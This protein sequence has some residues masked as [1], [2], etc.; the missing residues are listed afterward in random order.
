MGSERGAAPEMSGRHGIIKRMCRRMVR[1]WAGRASWVVMGLSLTILASGAVWAR[2]GSVPERSDTGL[3]SFSAGG[4]GTP[5]TPPATMRI[6]TLGG[7]AMSITLPGG[8]SMEFV[9]VPAG[10]FQM[11]SNDDSSWSWCHPC[12][13]PVRTVNI[14]E[15]FYLGRF[16]VTQAQWLAVMG[17][18]PGEA[19]SAEFGLGG[20]HPAYNISWNDVQEFIAALNSYITSTGQGPADLRLPSEAEWEYACRAGTRTQYYFGDSDCEPTDCD[21]CELDDHAW[22]CGNAGGRTHATGQLRPNALGLYDMSGNVWEWCEDAWHEN[23]ADPSRP[24]DGSP[25]LIPTA[26]ARVLRGGAWNNHA[27]FG[28]SSA[29][30]GNSQDGPDRCIGFR[31]ARPRSSQADSKAHRSWRMYE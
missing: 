25:W 28:R 23:Y 1:R 17:S 8:L 24:D 13:Q 30:I 27:Q 21:S 9:R 4:N 20:D 26:S 18:W 31:L 14:D 22:W 7:D 12:E 3:E 19:P 15:D 16:E 11:G 29:R 6:T 5:P 10:G 2:E